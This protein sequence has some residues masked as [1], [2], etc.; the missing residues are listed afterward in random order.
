MILK[1]CCRGI[2]G[3]NPTPGTFP[4]VAQ[5]IEQ[6]IS[7]PPVVGSN[8]TER[9]VRLNHQREK[10]HDDVRAESYEL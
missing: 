8:P 3:E 4:L 1:G 5:W 9:I 7:N 10:E 2:V 6:R